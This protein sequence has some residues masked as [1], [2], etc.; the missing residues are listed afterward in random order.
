MRDVATKW[1]QARP[2]WGTFSVRAHKDTRRLITDVLL[3]D[4]VVFPSPSSHNEAL[5][6]DDRGWNVELLTRRVIQLGPHAAVR[7]WDDHLRLLWRHRFDSLSE[8]AATPHDDL[9][10]DATAQVLAQQSFLDLFVGGDV[11]EPSLEDDEIYTEAPEPITE[12]RISAVA[13]DPPEILPTLSERDVRAVLS[14]SAG[15]V[16]LVASFQD[17]R[18]AQ[19]VTGAPVQPGEPVDPDNRLPDRALRLRLEVVV[20]DG[21]DEEATFLEAVRLLEN[22]DFRAAR[23]HLWSWEEELPADITLK[24]AQIRL[25][26][27]LD[28][29][30]EAVARRVSRRRTSAVFLAAPAAIGVASD[31]LIGG[32][33]SAAIGLGTSVALDRVKLKLPILNAATDATLHPGGALSSALAVVAH[34]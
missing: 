17:T 32:V 12:D 33:G 26:A 14:T 21:D 22:D 3:Y 23:R 27:L 16:K 29:F 19:V 1:P 10:F 28:D 24:E 20:P 7:P 34:D 31:L 5:R 25:T 13:A 11:V 30:N 4:M 9:A 6:W 2:R 18:Q 15:P 8:T